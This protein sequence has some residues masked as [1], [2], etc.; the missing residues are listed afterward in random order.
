MNP[1]SGVLDEAWR[2]YKTHARHLLAIAFVIYL[3]AA[4]ITAVLALAGGTVGLLLGSL[5]SV[6]AA[7]VLQATLIK[8]VQDVRD[9]RA[10]LSI[11]ETVN[12]ALPFFWSV[13]GASILAGIAIT[14]GLIL[15]IVPGLFLITIWAVIIPVIVIERS[16]VMASFGRSRELVRGRGWHVFGTLVIVYVIML[17][18]EIILS[19]IFS[20]L[21]HVLGDGLSSV[22]SGTLISP[23]LAVVVTLVYYRLSETM[24]P[25]GGGPYG[26]YQQSPQ[27]GGYGG[28]PP[29]PQGGYGQPPQSGGYGQPPQGGGYGGYREPPTSGYPQGDYPPPPP[30]GGYG[31]PPQ[32]QP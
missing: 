29:P 22:I 9:G 4:V 15:I 21:P 28:Y 19:L 30:P 18:V 14:I 10:D 25:A 8:A 7:F 23:F 13:A 2:M 11:S 5:V 17:V 6:I 3:I 12:Q 24:T 27:D 31:G 32:Q 26:G 20:A 1:L 16:G